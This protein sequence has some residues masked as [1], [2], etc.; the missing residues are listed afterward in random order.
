MSASKL[1]AEGGTLGC[2]VN[3]KILFRCGEHTTCSLL[4]SVYKD[5]DQAKDFKVDLVEV[6]K[7]VDNKVEEPNYDYPERGN[8]E[9]GSFQEGSQNGATQSERV[10]QM[11]SLGTVLLYSV[12]IYTNQDMF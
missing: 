9:D 3:L 10:S 12:A 5:V 2:R 1:R 4:K 7:G 11:N 6:D 8:Q